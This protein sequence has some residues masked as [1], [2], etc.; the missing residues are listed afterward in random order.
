MKVFCPT[1]KRRFATD[2]A[3]PIVC[4]RDGGHVLGGA[5]NDPATKTLWAYCC[6]CA[7]FMPLSANSGAETSCL[8]CER[9]ITTRFLCE[10]CQ[11][12][13]FESSESVKN[14]EFRLTKE[15]L[16]KPYC[17]G[18]LKSTEGN[19]REHECESLGV[20][21]LTLRSICPFDGESLS[22][23]PSFPCSV[24][25]LF[26]DAPDSFT[27]LEFD[28]D[29]NVLRESSLGDYA[30]G[31]QT[32]NSRLS[33]VIPKAQRL[34]SKRD[35][36]DKYYELFN[37]DNPAP[38]EVI[39]L[40]PAIVEKTENAWQLREAGF[41]EIKPDAKVE[42]V[43]AGPPVAIRC[44]ACGK[45]GEVGHVYCRYCGA[46]ML[47]QPSVAASA[48]RPEIEEKEQ[49]AESA[50]AQVDHVADNSARPSAGVSSAA[51]PVART[52]WKGLVA[53]VT[54]LVLVVIV[55]AIGA[56]LSGSGLLPAGELSVEKKLDRSIVA[57]H[58]FGPAP[59][60]AHDLYYQLKNSGASE[61]TL[62]PYREKLLP[63][64]TTRP[65]QMISNLMTPGSEDPPV[66][67]WQATIQPLRWAAELNP[68]D[69]VLSSR[70]IYCEGRVAYL[71]KQEDDALAAWKRAA[72]TDKAWPL[73]AN[74]MGLIYF[75]RKNYS[76]ARAYY[77]DA[78]RRDPNWAYPYN[79]LG[80]AFHYE[81]NDSAAKGYYRKA[82]ELAPHW[83]RPHAWLGEIAM[84]E[85]EFGAAVTEYEAVLDQNATGTTNMDLD[86]IRSKLEE[87]RQQMTFSQE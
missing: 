40:S 17:A 72:D 75:S 18:C 26:E 13:S 76:T 56:A 39:V 67:E 20:T 49:F 87:A 29:S 31:N 37:C 21:Y 1:H 78:V 14:K 84:K 2:A 43:V 28:A 27:T 30:L 33:M 50:D 61:T 6:N 60:N 64:L 80:T 51:V 71:L 23:P 52:Q 45:A 15:G 74:G 4:E 55:I 48:F 69:P 22:A 53:G 73:P 82:I 54:A 85:R 42:P 86:K 70:A 19:L 65:L 66:S 11:T 38:G 63:L 77:Q 12:L 32:R 5:P 59:D 46:P 35:Y 57:G 47:G 68:G 44:A 83:A 16:P 81:K 7:N 34:N 10:R 24:S 58:L 8:V 41:I 36:Y 3:T 79:N 62:R 25:K 9:K